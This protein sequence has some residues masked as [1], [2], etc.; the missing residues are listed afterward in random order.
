MCGHNH[1]RLAWARLNA[2]GILVAGLAILSLVDLL[3]P[4]GTDLARLIGEVPPGQ[5]VWV[6]GLGCAGLLMLHGFIRSDRITETIALV[7][8]NLCILAQIASAAYFLGFTEFTTTRIV[9]LGLVGAVTWARCSALWPQ[10]AIDIHIP[11]R[12]ES[13]DG[14]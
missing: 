5:T 7:V 6:T 1:D 8:L 3:H 4:G 11:G 12:G 9:I 10:D 14:P 2:Y 13:G